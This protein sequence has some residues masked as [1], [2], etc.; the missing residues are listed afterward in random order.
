MAHLPARIRWYNIVSRGKPHWAGEGFAHLLQNEQT[1]ES[2]FVIDP[3]VTARVKVL[4][5]PREEKNVVFALAM[6]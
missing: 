1:E 3:C 5:A 2:G 4:L 6:G